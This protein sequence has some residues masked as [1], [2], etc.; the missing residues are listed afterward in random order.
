MFDYGDRLDEL[1]LADL[2]DVLSLC[3]HPIIT[4]PEQL[5]HALQRNRAGP[6]VA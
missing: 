2:D 5:D 6:V 4:D 3:G 1:H